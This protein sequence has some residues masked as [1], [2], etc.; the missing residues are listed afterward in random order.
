VQRLRPAKP[1][2]EPPLFEVHLFPTVTWRNLPQRIA[3][4]VCVSLAA[5]IVLGVWRM[6]ILSR[7]GH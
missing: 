3:E 7:Q 5:A 4:G 1:P 2:E 6:L